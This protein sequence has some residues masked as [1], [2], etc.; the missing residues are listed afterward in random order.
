MGTLIP[1]IAINSHLLL[2]RDPT[3]LNKESHHLV[4]GGMLSDYGKTT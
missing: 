2:L 1:C 3:K 4:N